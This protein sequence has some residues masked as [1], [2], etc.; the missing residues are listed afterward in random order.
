MKTK[1]LKVLKGLLFVVVGLA[2]LLG[3][4]LAFENYRG[5]RAWEA[6]R[7]ELAAQ[8][9][10]LD[11]SEL[12]PPPV[13][14]DQNFFKTPLLAP[15][16]DL[17]PEP[18]HRAYHEPRDSNAVARVGALFDSLN[19]ALRVQQA[20]W[21][22]A[23]FTDLAAMQT[24]LRGATNT[25]NPDLQALQAT[26]VGPPPADLLFLLGRKSAELEE[27]RAAL[28]RPQARYGIPAADG[29]MA[30]VPHLAP[31]R[32]FSRAF[33]TKALAELA[34]GQVDAAAADVIAALEVGRT[35]ESEPLLIATL[36]EIA[37]FG[38]AMQPL[39][40]GLARHQWTEPH[41]ARFE[42]ELAGFN[43]VTGMARTLRF[44]RAY[45]L[46]MLD[47]WRR[48]PKQAAA[49][50]GDGETSL[51]MP[52]TRL[53]SGW[54]RLTQVSMA[55]MFQDHL[56]PV[57]D[58]NRNVVDIRLGERLAKQAEEQLKGW[59]PYKVLARQLF[60][61]LSPAVNRAASAQTILNQA[62]LAVALERFRLAEGQFPAELRELA[63]RFLNVIP[64]DAVNGEPYRYRREAPDRFLLYSVGAN[65]EDDGAEVAQDKRGRAK[66][67]DA[68][69][70]WVWRSPPVE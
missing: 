9:E 29:A 70:D 23:Q 30:L 56:V 64:L 1:W 25:R 45:A 60:P 36:V 47:S 57:L 32:A 38:S 34:N 11:W 55:R 42:A 3:L 15:L 21:R 66:P 18:V 22:L 65:L 48:K 50:I 5:K 35:L 14:D 10:K 40:E 37:V 2:T 51:A 58:T 17:V 52:P 7:A 44:E 19:P 61:A 53:P 12:V 62:R 68:E 49:G 26:P 20:S 28:R 6:C 59:S 31:L 4:I 27:I 39:W 16:A 33:A 41:L 63:P 54:I 43:F 69:G 13:P 8:G 24:E 67:Y 46:G